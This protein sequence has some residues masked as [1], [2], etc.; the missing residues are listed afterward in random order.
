[1]LLDYSYLF[2]YACSNAYRINYDDIVEMK[3]QLSIPKIIL[4]LGLFISTAIVEAQPSVVQHEK[5]TKGETQLST[6]FSIELS[7]GNWYSPLILKAYHHDNDKKE[8]IGLTR[9][10]EFSSRQNAYAISED[11]KTLLYFHQK[12]PDDGGVNKPSGLYEYRHG[13]GSERIHGFV[14]NAVFLSTHLP[15]NIIVY[16]QLEKIKDSMRLDS[17][18]YLRDTEGNQKL[19]TQK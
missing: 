14:S 9:F 7:G 6:Y 19:W 8:L 13:S 16:A 2:R 1:M 4:I 15:R 10:S 3:Q 5:I 18:N 12:L 17:K 11:G